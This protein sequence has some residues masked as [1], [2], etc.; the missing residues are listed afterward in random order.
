MTSQP[1]IVLLVENWNSLR[2]SRNRKIITAR[3]IELYINDTL[4]GRKSTILQLVRRM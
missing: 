4:E 2:E 1:L 3:I